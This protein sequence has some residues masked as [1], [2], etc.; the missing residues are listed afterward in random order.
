MMLVIIP[1]FC[2]TERIGKS[3]KEKDCKYSW[4]SICV[5]MTCIFAGIRA[6]YNHVDLKWP[7][8][9]CSPVIAQVVQRM[10]NTIHPINHHPVDSVYL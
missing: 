10:D 5:Y 9:E 3:E 8:Q 2:F 7:F 6:N 4:H 1:Y